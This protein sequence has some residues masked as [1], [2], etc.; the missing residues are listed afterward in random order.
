MTTTKAERVVSETVADVKR[1][2][3]RVRSALELTARRKWRPGTSDRCPLET[4][5]GVGDI[6]VPGSERIFVRD[7]DHAAKLRKAGF[8]VEPRIHSVGWEVRAP[9]AVAH[10][11]DFAD[12]SGATIGGVHYDVELPAEIQGVWRGWPAASTCPTNTEG[13]TQ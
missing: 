13:S 12:E 10:F 1:F 8:H 7:E 9:E 5:I 4:M 3:N 11:V 6:T 2:A